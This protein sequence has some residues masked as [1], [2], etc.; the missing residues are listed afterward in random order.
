M[1]GAG[2][3]PVPTVG[4][5]VLGVTKSLSGRRYYQPTEQGLEER[6]RARIE[7]IRRIRGK[8]KKAPAKTE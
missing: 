8:A 4:E 2:D 3:G 6:L 5:T 1:A 7:E